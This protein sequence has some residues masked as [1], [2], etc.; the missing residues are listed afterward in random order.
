[1]GR[2]FW[3]EKTSDGKSLWQREGNGYAEGR[4]RGEDGRK[5]GNRGGK[6][7]GR[8]RRKEGRHTRGTKTKS[9]KKNESR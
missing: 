1:M 6:V 2:V 5:E 7:G 8:E 9:A 3:I 4:R